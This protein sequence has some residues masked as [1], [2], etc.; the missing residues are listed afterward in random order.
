[1]AIDARVTASDQRGSGVAGSVASLVRE[2]QA[3]AGLRLSV[4]RAS[5]V[6]VIG[7]H[8]LM[9]MRARLW[10]AD[11]FH[12]PAH[13]L[14][15]ARFGIPAVVT[16]NDLA[17]YDHP[18]WFPDRQWISTT[19][20]VPH[21]VRGARMV[22]CPSEATRRAV[23]AR[24]RVSEDRCRVI[25]HGVDSVFALPVS[26]ADRSN[27]QAHYGLPDRFILQVG[28]VQPRK[29]HVATLRA[30]A[31]IPE[32]D[33]VPFVVAGEFG[34]KFEPVLRTVQELALTRWVRFIGYV[35]PSRLPALYQTATVLVFPSLDEGFGLPVLEAFAAGTPVVASEVGAISEVAKDAA[36]LVPADDT[37]A[38]AAA[39]RAALTDEARR[40]QLVE[41]GR[42]RVA[43]YSWTLS[44]QAHA[45]AYRE[46]A[47]RPAPAPTTSMSPPSPS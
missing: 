42:Q 5:R 38:L 37:A 13:G 24:F 32:R 2:L 8:L 10:G 14:P 12:G 30:L 23:M 15:L 7:P 43:E 25:P 31:A 36:M 34:W 22:I 9:P 20:L 46:A 26:A 21:S 16:I 45:R 29:N 28:T 41:R 44:A 33:R 17:I 6:P 39:L 35:E 27:L 19:V 1:V 47:G 40:A 11:V 3:I 4:Y 18:E